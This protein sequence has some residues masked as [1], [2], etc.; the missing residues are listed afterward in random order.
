MIP[1]NRG[2]GSLITGTAVET[3]D[4]RPKGTNERGFY[5]SRVD[6]PM[7]RKA[8]R[9]DVIRARRK[10]SSKGSTE[11]EGCAGRAGVD[12]GWGRKEGTG[13]RE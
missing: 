12:F 10:G 9:S 7:E 13:A 6:Q 3:N 4:P 11:D 1:W 5:P 2:T 8:R